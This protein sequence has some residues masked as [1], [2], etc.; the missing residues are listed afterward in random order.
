MDF[1]IDA[2]AIREIN[3]PLEQNPLANQAT[4]RRLLFA[5]PGH[6]S[7]RPFPTCVSLLQE[8]RHPSKFVRVS[9]AN[10][11]LGIQQTNLKGS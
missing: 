6:H 2:H 5:I 3:R 8:Q 7:V 10:V 9:G 4:D 1:P 11:L